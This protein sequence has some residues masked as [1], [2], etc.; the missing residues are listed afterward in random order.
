MS[1]SDPDRGELIRLAREAVAAEVN[2]TRPPRLDK[3]QGIL[4]EVRGAF[5][6]LTNAGR[7]RG[8]IGQFQPRTPLAV[9]VVEM[10]RAAA[11]DPR[12]IYYRP[13]TPEELSELAVEVSVLTPLV[14]TAE[15][16]KL[17]V[18][19]HGIYIISGQR[20]GCFLPEVATDQGWT[21]EQFLTECC[22]GKAGLPPDAWRQPGARVY[23]FESEKFDH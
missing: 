21:A 12:F 15:P 18:G 16:A 9:T 2:G 23:L 20:A 14:E 11:K 8:C 17:E 19:R 5:V 3:P 22:R 4:A 13:I 7:L 10:G 6:T 1:I